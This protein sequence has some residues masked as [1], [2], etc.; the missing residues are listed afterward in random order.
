MAEPPRQNIL[1]VDI[2]GSGRGDDVV[3]RVRRR[4]MYETVAY[5]LEAAEVGTA[6]HR[7]ED[8]GDGVLVLVSAG[9]SK[10]GLLRAV[11]AEIPARL[12]AYNRLADESA[13]VRLRVVLAAGEVAL[14]EGPGVLG[15]AV[16]RDLDQ[17]FRLLDGDPLREALRRRRGRPAGLEDALL[18]VSDA[19]FQGVARHDHRGI[20]SDAF[21][22]ITV[23]GK[24]GLVRGWVYGVGAPRAG[25]RT[26]D[27]PEPAGAE[28]GRAA[29]EAPETA[30][31]AASRGGCVAGD[32][33][34][35]PGGRVGGDVVMRDKIV[36]QRRS[37]GERP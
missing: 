26:R 22:P 4:Q 21:Q 6:D 11:L 25:E 37:R 3:R 36:G 17:A 5:A 34:G 35:V 31:A 12:H 20:R 10:V 33:H 32:V 1:L 9:V 27:T 18:C 29:V 19:V 30:T 15:G 13:R 14:D 16:G 7:V 23:P 28:P 2:K 24:E 8:R